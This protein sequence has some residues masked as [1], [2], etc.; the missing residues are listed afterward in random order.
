MSIE[1]ID[2]SETETLMKGYWGNRTHLFVDP[3][4]YKAYHDET[5]DFNNETEQGVGNER[6]A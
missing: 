2:Q 5:E 3:D 4:P 6:Q 1:V